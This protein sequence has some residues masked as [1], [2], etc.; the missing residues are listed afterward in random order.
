MHQLI[1]ADRARA[2]FRRVIRVVALTTLAALGFAQSLGHAAQVTFAWDYSA[3]GAAGFAVYCGGASGAYTSRYDA[4][5]ALAYTVTNAAEGSRLFCAVTAYD[6][7]K[8]ETSYSAELSVQVPYKAPVTSFAASPLTGTAPLNV[9][10]SN[11]T[12]GTVT[13]W[14]WDFGDGTTSTAQ[15]PSHTYSVAGSFTPSLTATGPGG[16]TKVTA[17]TPI[18]VTTPTTTVTAPVAKFTVSPLS[19][20]APL[21]VAFSNTTTGTVT[22]YSWN[23]GDGT[24]STAQSPSHTYSAAGTYY[25]ILTATNSA[26]SSTFTATTPIQVS[27]TTVTPTPTSKTGLM[28]AYGFE[29]GTGTILNDRVRGN[30][31]TISNATWTNSGKYGKALV[32]DGR[33]SIVTVKDSIT[34]DLT[35]AMTLEA[36][37]YP[38]K[39]SLGWATIIA[40]EQPGGIVYDLYGG[41]SSGL[42]F[43]GVYIS[44]E[45]ILNGTSPLPANTWTH[46]ASTYDGKVHRLYVNGVQVASRAQTGKILASTGALRIGGN[47]LWGEYFTGRI[48]EL[49][50]YNRALTASE[51]ASDMQTKVGP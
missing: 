35:A 28:A 24:S 29:E 36:W 22:S 13:S 41:S 14:S 2:A 25:P 47:G 50:I 33:S 42:P 51:I 18:K 32:F 30:K 4:G 17:S 8:V 38:T 1:R 5:N 9:S 31:G 6:S 40:K 26:G 37:V 34:L 19:G 10:F 44:G 23:F 11:T 43:S 46:L 7:S 20:T 16:T 21:T 15:N 27:G 45:K 3:S 49:R 48:D 12:T 39:T